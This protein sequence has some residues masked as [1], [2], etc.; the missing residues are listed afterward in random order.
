[1]LQFTTANDHLLEGSRRE[2]NRKR[3]IVK[4]SQ[5]YGEIFYGEIFRKGES[6][7][8]HPIN[9]LLHLQ[10]HVLFDEQIGLSPLVV[11]RQAFSYFD[12]GPSFRSISLFF[13]GGTWSA[14]LPVGQIDL[15]QLHS[16]FQFHLLLQCCFS[17]HQCQCRSPHWFLQE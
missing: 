5:L 6:F 14:P 11:V 10:F 15:C 3:Q 16:R 9:L 8:H 2:A 1:M 12:I 7:K 17:P 13:S 4:I